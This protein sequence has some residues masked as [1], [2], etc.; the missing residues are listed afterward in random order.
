VLN[1][2]QPPY[3]LQGDDRERISGARR[4]AEALFA[5]K[6]EPVEPSASDSV[7]SVEQSRKPRVL[8]ISSP[9][10]VRNKDVAPPANPEPQ[11]TRE[12]P[13]SQYA[14]IRTWVKY[15]MTISQVAKVYGVAVG[16]IERILRPA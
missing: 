12:I 5:P 9:A 8:A 6:R 1:R 3:H 14:R 4:A 2:R 15:G 10:P 16:V 13:R 11:T 7:A